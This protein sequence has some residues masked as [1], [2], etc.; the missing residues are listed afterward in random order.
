M[1]ECPFCSTNL[2]KADELHHCPGSKPGAGDR[3]DERVEQMDAP[4]PRVSLRED[5]DDDLPPAA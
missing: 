1:P 4:E 3:L 2:K 5:Q